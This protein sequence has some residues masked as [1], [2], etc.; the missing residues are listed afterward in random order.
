MDPHKNPEDKPGRA[1]VLMIRD[2]PEVLLP[3]VYQFWLLR[4]WTVPFCSWHTPH[5]HKHS[6]P[7]TLT[8]TPMYTHCH[9][10]QAHSHSILTHTAILYT[11]SY[12]QTLTV[13]PIPLTQSY[14]TV[15]SIHTF[16]PTSCILSTPIHPITPKPTHTVIYTHHT[17]T[18]HTYY[19]SHTISKLSL[20]TQLIKQVV[21]PVHNVIPTHCHPFI[22]SHSYSPYSQK[23]C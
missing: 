23:Y 17:I 3:V 4:C 8:A 18:S 12:P 15:T 10:T 5:T 22:H 2:W 9:H 21:T 7:H 19:H 13:T 11:Q 20:P 14:P 16:I 1:Q 6:H